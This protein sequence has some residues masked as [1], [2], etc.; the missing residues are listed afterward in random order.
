MKK[1]LLF[2]CQ[3]N[4]LRSR[5]AEELF[6]DN[7][8]YEIKSAGVSKDAVQPI[9]EELLEWADIIFVM[10]KTHRNKI[11]KLFPGIYKRK[12]IECLYIPDE[13]DFMDPVLVTILKNKLEK[14]LKQK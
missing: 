10:E 7:P 3:V 4:R 2:I 13:Y 8:N 9:T 12:N 5:T 6:K 14:C 11:R 1:K